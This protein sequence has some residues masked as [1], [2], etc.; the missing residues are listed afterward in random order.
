MIYSFSSSWLRLLLIFPSELPFSACV[1]GGDFSLRCHI[2]GCVVYHPTLPL[3]P[4]GEYLEAMFAQQKENNRLLEQQ[5]KKYNNHIPPTSQPPS[6]TAEP[7][8][9]GARMV[10][11]EA[12]CVQVLYGSWPY[13][14]AQISCLP[15]PEVLQ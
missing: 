13:T 1:R 11:M 6:R 2:K 15:C 7:L 4:T 5:T 10:Q 9:L 14:T 3:P 12:P 8:R